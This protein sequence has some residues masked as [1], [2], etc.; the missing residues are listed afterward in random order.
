MKN[1]SMNFCFRRRILAMKN[2]KVLASEETCVPAVWQ[3]FSDQYDRNLV[4]IGATALMTQE[5]FTWENYYE[6]ITWEDIIWEN[7]N[8]CIYPLV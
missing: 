2:M 5:D 6:I 7:Y 1:I 4:N 3:I 8:N